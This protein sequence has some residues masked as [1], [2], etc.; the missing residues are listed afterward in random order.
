[1]PIFERLLERSASRK[2]KPGGNQCNS[3]G[4]AW[5]DGG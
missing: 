4:F 1:M 5:D 2:E 3:L